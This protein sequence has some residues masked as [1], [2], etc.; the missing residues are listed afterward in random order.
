MITLPIVWLDLVS[1]AFKASIFVNGNNR[2]IKRIKIKIYYVH[3]TILGFKYKK[4]RK[5][6]ENISFDKIISTG[7][8]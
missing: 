1:Y 5:R 7:A 2:N 8:S 4:K 6:K 3:N